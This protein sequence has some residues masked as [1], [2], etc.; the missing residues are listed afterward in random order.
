EGTVAP[1]KRQA[2]PKRRFYIDEDTW[3]AV[4]YDGWDAQGQLWRM[5]RMMPIVRPDVPGTISR[6]FGIYNLLAG[7]Y[8]TGNLPA[9]LPFQFRQVDPRPDSYFTPDNLAAKGTR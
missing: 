7:T 4:L 2:V 9:G 5:G 1:G 6:T 3:T 8:Q